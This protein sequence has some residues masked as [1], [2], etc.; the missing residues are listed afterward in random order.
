MAFTNE[1][2]ESEI[3][4]LTAEA[5]RKVSTV[6]AIFLESA[7]LRVQAEHL[8]QLLALRTQMERH[9]QL[10]SFVLLGF[11]GQTEV[12]PI[13]FLA[14]TWSGSA[15]FPSDTQLLINRGWQTMLPLEIIPYFTELLE[16]WKQMIQTR[17]ALVLSMIGE[18]SVG[19]IRTIEQGTIHKDRIAQFI[20]RR[21]GDIVYYPAIALVT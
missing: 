9:T 14:A 21:L 20:S 15:S 8:K 11:V 2:I 7:K 16:D 1:Q 10:L 13:A 18:L 12:E 4:E 19:P 5:D 6:K 17:P 3:A